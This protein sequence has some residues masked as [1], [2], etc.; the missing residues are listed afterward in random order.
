MPT[1]LAQNIRFLRKRKPITQAG[2]ALQLGKSQTA[3]GNWE[4][5]YSEPSIE[6]LEKIT[7]FFGVSYDD[8]LGKDLSKGNLIENSDGVEKGNLKGNLMGNLKPENRTISGLVPREISQ[9]KTGTEGG[10]SLPYVVYV[11][12][13]GEEVAVLVQVKDRTAYKMGYNDWEFLDTLPIYRLADYPGGS[14]RLFEIEGQEMAPNFKPGD[15]AIARWAQVS[16]IQEGKVHVLVT[17]SQG[18]TIRRIFLQPNGA[19]FICKSDN[20]NKEQ[21]PDLTVSKEDILE[22]WAVVATISKHLPSA[23]EWA[24]RLANVEDYIAWMKEK[25]G[26]RPNG[27]QME[28]N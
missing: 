11:D 17:R 28:V 25:L 27:T 8:L 15:N 18:L 9:Q 20:E 10:K 22:V 2:L 21:Y 23:D 13:T 19:K 24:N 26:D 3:V 6:D 1:T 16:A 14:I 12:G 4:S 5:D 7:R